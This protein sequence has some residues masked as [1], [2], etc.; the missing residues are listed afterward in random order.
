V[1]KQKKTFHFFKFSKVFIAN[2]RSNGKA[3]IS[4]TIKPWKIEEGEKP[5][6]SI[7]GKQFGSLSI[8]QTKGEDLKYEIR[9]GSEF[10]S[11]G[12]TTGSNITIN[13]DGNS[14]YTI[15]IINE[16]DE[17]RPITLSVEKSG[18]GS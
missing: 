15:T 12:H 7:S 6:W 9:R 14:T 1:S 17:A 5:N 13:S 8:K 18:S 2:A 10:L 11:S 4:S 3:T 16:E